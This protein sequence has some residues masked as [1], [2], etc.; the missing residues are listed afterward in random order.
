MI[1]SIQ[2]NQNLKHGYIYSLLIDI[3]NANGARICTYRKIIFSLNCISS[4]QLNIFLD[5]CGH[6]EENMVSRGELLAP[7]Q[8]TPCR[9]FSSTDMANI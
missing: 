2:T 9:A 5:I 8:L 6:E 3:E 1:F 7:S 4:I